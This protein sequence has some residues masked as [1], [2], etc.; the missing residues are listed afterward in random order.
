[1][2]PSP[3]SAALF[4]STR[5]RRTPAEVLSKLADS[6]D[7]PAIL[8]AFNPQHPAYK[9]LKAQLAAARSGKFSEIDNNRGPV[10][11]VA[12]PQKETEK[13]KRKSK[14]AK[15]GAAKAKPAAAN[16]DTIIANR[17]RWRWMPHDLGSTYVMVNIPDFT[18]KVVQ[19]G[20]T[21]WQ[22]L[23][24]DLHFMNHHVGAHLGSTGWSVAEHLM[25]EDSRSHGFELV[26]QWQLNNLF[27]ANNGG[28]GFLVSSATPASNGQW[29]GLSTFNNGR[30]GMEITGV[31]TGQRIEG[32]R[33]SDSFFGGDRLGEIFCDSYATAPHYF[34]NVYCECQ[35]GCTGMVFT[36]NN[37]TICLN[38]CIATTS[39]A[40][41]GLLSSAPYTQITGGVY[42]AVALSAGVGLDITRGRVSVIG[43]RVTGFSTNIRASGITAASIIGCYADHSIN[44][45]ET[46]HVCTT[47]NF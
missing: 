31:S 37:P 38:G 41:H 30:F 46:T 10:K 15:E 2:W 4:I 19:D 40:G 1:V 5:R 43:A 39:G 34:T 3:A 27:A 8:D 29:R 28:S 25:S 11:A 16:V 7:V 13:D 45:A 36:A 20:K 26:G 12:E 47:G 17:E 42:E 23:L 44:T 22:C 24:Y 21:V 9:A 14:G 35:A 33:I 18:L 6:T 32:L